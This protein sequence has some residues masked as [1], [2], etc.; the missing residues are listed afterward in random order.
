MA[1]YY[2]LYFKLLAKKIIQYKI[3]LEDTYNIDK[4][5]FLLGQLLKV[6]RIFSRAAFENSR[7]KHIIQDSNKE[8]ITLIVI[9]YVDGI[10]LLLGLIY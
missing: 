3:K 6:K 5:E 1:Y 7:I 8:W 4:K 2:A 10:Y 9:I